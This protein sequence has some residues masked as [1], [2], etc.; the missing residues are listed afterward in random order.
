[1]RADGWNVVSTRDMADFVAVK[2]GKVRFI[3]VYNKDANG[4]PVNST[5][6]RLLASAGFEVQLDSTPKNPRHTGQ[7]RIVS[8]NVTGEYVP[9]LEKLKQVLEVKNK[10]LSTW[11]REKMVDEVMQQMAGV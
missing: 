10:D 2:D 5:T 7:R 1:M 4:D 11:F 9:F 8:V 6:M 3:Q